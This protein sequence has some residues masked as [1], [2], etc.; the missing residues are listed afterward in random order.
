VMGHRTRVSLER[1]GCSR[2]L[3]KNPNKGNLMKNKDLSGDAKSNR[4][5]K[6]RYLRLRNL[7]GKFRANC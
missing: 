5:M 3:R 6:M 2:A 7:G 1:G 4:G